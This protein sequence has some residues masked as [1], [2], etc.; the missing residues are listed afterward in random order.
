[1]RSVFLLLVL[2]LLAPAG[3]T[4]TPFVGHAASTTKGNLSL[5]D[6]FFLTDVAG[7]AT[8]SF[9]VATVAA[10]SGDL[11]VVEKEGVI[12]VVRDGAVL[13]QPFIDLREEVLNADD[14]GLLGL[15]FDPDFETNRYVYL[16]Y[17]VAEDGV[18]TAPDGENSRV[19]AFARVT[20]YTANATGTR[21]RLGTRRVLIGETWSQG[22]PACYH[23][24]SVGTVQFGL[25]G[26]LLVGTGDAAHFVGIDPG[27]RYDACFGEGPQGQERF[28]L[29]EDIGAFRSQRLESLAGKVLRVDPETGLGLPDNPFWTGDGADNASR[30][31]ALGFRNPFRFHVGPGEGPG[32]LHLGDVGFETWEEVNVVRRGDNGGWPCFEGPDPV[33]AYQDATPATNG[34]DTVPTQSAP[35]Y[36]WNHADPAESS[37]AGRVA[38][39]AVGGPVYAG[40]RYPEAYRGRAFYGDYATQ[41][42]ATSAVDASGGLSDDALFS[43]GAG[44]VVHIGYDPATQWMTLTDVGTEPGAGK[45]W[46]LRHVDGEGNSAPVA[47]AGASVT[48]GTAPL[49]VAFSG[50]ASFDPDGD[51]ITYLWTFG[52]D[53]VASEPDPTHV[54]TQAG[55]FTARLTVTDGAGA[56][57]SAAVEITVRDGVA[58]TATI[59]SPPEGTVIT[60]ADLE[61]GEA[62]IDLV[63]Q[64]TDPDQAPE[65]LDYAWTVAL[66]HNSHVHPDVFSASGPA[67]T[68][69]VEPHGTGG[70]Y[71][72]IR[73]RLTVTDSEG[74]SDTAERIVPFEYNDGGSLPPGWTSQ[75]LGAPAIDGAAFLTDDGA[76]RVRGSGDLWGLDDAAHLVTREL[77]GDGVITARVASVTGGEAD[78]GAKAGVILRTDL[79]PQ[80]PYA[81]M[82]LS[83]GQG[84][85]AQWR[86]AAGQETQATGE[87]PESTA[88]L[89]V[90]LERRGERVRSFQSADG[91]TWLLVAETVLPLAETVLVGLAVTAT[92]IAFEGLVANAI[93]TDVGVSDVPEALPPFTAE[94]LGAT[95]VDG[96]TVADGTSVTMTAGGDLWGRHDAGHLAYWA[97][98]GDGRLTARLDTLYGGRPDGNAK[99]GL[100]LRRSLDVQAANAFV[101]ASAENGLRFQFRPDAQ[102]MTE[103][104]DGEPPTTTPVWL[105]IERI[106]QEVVGS[107]SADGATWEVLGQTQL[108]LS[109][110]AIVALATTATDYDYAGL[111]ATAEFSNVAF[112]GTGTMKTLSF[113]DAVAAGLAQARAFEITAVFPNPTR[114]QARVR[115]GVAEAGRVTVDLVDA[116]GR[117]V[118]ERAVEE[119]APGDRAVVFDV[120][121]Y[122]PGVYVVRARAATGEV[123][124]KRLTVVR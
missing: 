23:S 106:G 26:S 59:A 33:Q 84:A 108:P 38:F 17:V 88:S 30:V 124:H 120:S 66:L 22:I 111:R 121:G 76:F 15:A 24:H 49:E 74:L 71:Y 91:Q 3:V 70:D 40:T 37:P 29:S 67:A 18:E 105:R 48:Q 94:D 25:D 75:T 93:F 46:Q 31:W 65:T 5:P 11:Y 97:L 9:P 4:Q 7:G 12:R 110:H 89:W 90:R 115:L 42:I 85:W 62:L 81:M 68:Y 56:S 104:V 44:F 39:A 101:G 6:G 8:F 77:T 50:S 86:P 107:T 1:M 123:T 80:G 79:D 64:A 2:C 118:A 122:A 28:P 95:L 27:G 72:A 47:Q 16:S 13:P 109:E 117:V 100:M 41:W 92:D 54:Y 73:I 103:S 112:E 58:P 61:S 14:R 113:D 20:R 43:L 34:C 82:Y 52:D 51:A 55:T 83:P 53:A 102:E 60:E 32:T 21:A 19:D 63:G 10:P 98:E 36:W 78:G 119:T 87:Q 35:R 57:T 114:S 96:S 99:A 116:L 45:V 69:A